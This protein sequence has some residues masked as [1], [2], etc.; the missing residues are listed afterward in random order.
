MKVSG[1]L[2]L[3]LIC[4]LFGACKKDSVIN[5]IVIE[6][7]TMENYPKVDG[8]TSTDPL[9]RLIASKLL[10]YEYSWERADF[11]NGLGY[12]KTNLPNEFVT[13]RLKSSQTHNSIINLI[14]KKAD[15]ILAARKMSPDEKLYAE[16][17]GVSLIETPIALDA[18]IFVANLD[19]P[20]K[21]L[22]T[23][24]VQ[25][26]YTGK[27]KN[28]KEVGGNDAM[29][30]PYTRNQNSGSQELMESLVMKGLTP[31]NFEIDHSP[32]LPSM[33]LVFT[34]IR[35]DVNAL[36]YTVYY[37]K[38][39][40]V[41]DPIV[42]SLAIDGVNPDK[43]SIKNKTYRYVAEVYAT[44]RSDLDRNSMAYKLFELLQSVE[45]KSAISESGY[46]PN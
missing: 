37:Y 6:G 34:R 31:G 27:I 4:L 44:I 41:R 13:D 22:T 14:D 42:K 19:N 38:D 5:P 39:H 33:S 43:K 3:L 29:I 20:V 9:N 28:W 7:I 18:F 17:A 32:E 16:N 2:K 11:M 35:S 24:Q 36:G 10:G 8:S 45:G 21:S 23:K 30:K 1:Y 26:I 25:D 40:I 15:I 12:L 46:I